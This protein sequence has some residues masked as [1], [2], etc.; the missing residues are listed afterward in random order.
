MTD[1]SLQVQELN[2]LAQQLATLVATAA[3]TPSE[4]QALLDQF[5]HRTLASLQ[6]IEAAAKESFAAGGATR[7]SGPTTPISPAQ[8][9]S[10]SAGKPTPE[11]MEWVRQQINEED[12]VAGLHEIRE[13]GGLE[14]RDFIDELEKAATADE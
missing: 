12:I 6:E 1:K 11:I 4:S 8:N 5:M 9:N 2:K 13:T 3:R 10:A 14:L 7:E